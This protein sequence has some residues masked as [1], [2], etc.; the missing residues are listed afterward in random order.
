MKKG[1]IHGVTG[2]D[3]KFDISFN[4]TIA[5][6]ANRKCDSACGIS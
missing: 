3:I 4:G 5:A 1:V 6:D 2:S